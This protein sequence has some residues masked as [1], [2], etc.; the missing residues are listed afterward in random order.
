MGL[1]AVCVHQAAL[2]SVG[3]QGHADGWLVR[4]GQ[5]IEAI[6]LPLNAPYTSQYVAEEQAC[7]PRGFLAPSACGCWVA[8]GVTGSCEHFEY[9]SGTVWIQADERAKPAA[10]RPCRRKTGELTPDRAQTDP[11]PC[12]GR[13][14]GCAQ[15]W[16]VP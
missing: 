3:V 8:A 14:N 9:T 5:P 10:E 6:C 12:Q 1:R 16:G 15:F 11:L 7:Q 13:E 4:L 2:G